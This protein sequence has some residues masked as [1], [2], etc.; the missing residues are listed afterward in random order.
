[1][2]KALRAACMATMVMLIVTAGHSAAPVTVTIIAE[3]RDASFMA[4]GNDRNLKPLIRI[5]L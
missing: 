4:D 5:S 1:M 3:T 2:A